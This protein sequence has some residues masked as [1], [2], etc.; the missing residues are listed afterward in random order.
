MLFD[1][2]PDIARRRRFFEFEFDR[3]TKFF[4][5][6]QQPFRAVYA[7][8]RNE[9]RPV[10][11]QQKLEGLEALRFRLLRPDCRAGDEIGVLQVEREGCIVLAAPVAER[12]AV[13]V[14]AAPS[15]EQ[16]A[17]GA[18]RTRTGLQHLFGLRCIWPVCDPAE[19]RAGGESR[20]SGREGVA[21][22]VAA[23]PFFADLH[24][25]GD[26]NGNRFSRLR[27]S[28]LVAPD[29]NFADD[30]LRGTV[31]HLD[32]ELHILRRDRFGEWEFERNA[33]LIRFARQPVRECAGG[34]RNEGFAV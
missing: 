23:Q 24:I 14:G 1:P 17:A 11:R 28:G 2:E 6:V 34:G 29:R 4:S 13:P 15:V 26:R 20:F 10:R 9:F 18:V 12:L 25:R 33:E 30:L 31:A 21:G 32:P 7:A 22:R 8:D 27:A 16:D 19:C 5:L 3:F